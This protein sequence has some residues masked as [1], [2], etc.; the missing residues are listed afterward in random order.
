V[1]IVEQ[2]GS[3]KVYYKGGNGSVCV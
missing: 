1:D 2:D 3:A